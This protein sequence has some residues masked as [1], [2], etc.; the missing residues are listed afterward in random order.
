MLDVSSVFG[1][2]LLL[3]CLLMVYERSRRSGELELVDWSLL[4][5]GGLYG[6]GYFFVLQCTRSG[7]NTGWESYILPYQDYYIILNAAVV[8][9]ICGLLLGWRF[10]PR[11]FP[12][13][14]SSIYPRRP[15]ACSSRVYEAGFWLVLITG[16]LSQMIYVQAHGGLIASLEYSRLIRSA[17][18][19]S[20][21]DN[22]YSFLQ[23]IRTMSLI[24]A[25][26]FFA[27]LL[28]TGKSKLTISAG[29]VLSLVFSAYVLFS[30]QGRLAFVVYMSVF[31]FGRAFYN[32]LPARY[33]LLFLGVVAPFS[34]VALFY[35]SIWMG[36]K[37]SDDIISFVAKEI[38]FPYASFFAQLD[39]EEYLFRYFYDILISP[40]FL[41]PSSLWSNWIES[42]SQVNTEVLIGAAKGYGQTTGIPV[43]ILTLGLMQF[44]LLGV[45]LMGA[46]AGFLL[47]AFQVSVDSIENRGIQAMSEAYIV[48]HFAMLAMCYAQPSLVISANIA[49]FLAVCILWFTHVV[50]KVR[51]RA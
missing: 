29:L 14:I 15:I 7:L 27:L 45:F 12:N 41:L 2:L 25:F 26:G 43:D 18:F 44:H 48:V 50:S 5:I 10:S 28:N 13:K 21:P 32:R 36:L 8:L 35:I 34:L 38:S 40:V 31:L 20:V 30:R 4:A 24:A 37:P 22:P 23:P 51:V 19:S 1:L 42:V 49:F 11:L 33:M 39:H 6:A 16:I 3:A 9:L 47:R 17:L 46:I